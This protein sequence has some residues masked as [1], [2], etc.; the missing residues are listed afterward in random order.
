M[1]LTGMGIALST[2]ASY[3]SRLA[4]AL[5]PSFP[6]LHVCKG[7]YSAI[8]QLHLETNHSMW[9]VIWINVFHYFPRQQLICKLLHLHFQELE[10][11]PHDN[12]DRSPEVLY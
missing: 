8:P 5:C 12:H 3:Y 6:I 2:A 11:V 1:D 4:A 9:A 10:E 7:T